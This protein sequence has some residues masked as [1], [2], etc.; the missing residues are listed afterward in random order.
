[1]CI[2]VEWF[3][4]HGHEGEGQKLIDKCPSQRNAIW[5]EHVGDGVELLDD[6][7]C[8]AIVQKFTKLYFSEHMDA[9]R[10]PRWRGRFIETR[11]NHDGIWI[12]PLSDGIQIWCQSVFL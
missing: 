6:K 5:M 9:M 4:A 12:S 3:P 1:M 2:T 8:V 10:V 11:R 7:V